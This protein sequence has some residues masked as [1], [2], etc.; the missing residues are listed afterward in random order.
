M[1]TLN[2]IG[3]EAVINHHNEVPYR[4]LR[5]NGEL[6][7]GDTGNGNLLV[8][9]D[10][11]EALKALLPYFAGQVKCIYIDPPYNTGH[12]DWV[13]SDSVSSPQMQTWLGKVVGGE[14]LSRHDK[15]LCMMYP[16]LR[17]LWELLSEGGSLW[18]S[19]DD[20]EIQS[21]RA[22]L[23]EIF[24]ERNFI[25]TICWQ[26]IYTVKSTA[27]H[28]SEMHDY[29]LVY[30]KDSATWTRNL[31]DRTEKQD[32]AYSNPDNDPRGPWK[33][34]PIHARNYYSEGQYAI[35]CPSGRVIPGPPT[36]TYWRYPESKFRALDEDNQIW[37]G[38][39]GNNVPAQKRFL[40][41]VK[42]GVVPATMWFYREAGHN[43]EAKNELRQILS[44]S[45][46]MFITP[47]P[48]R[49]VR[50]ILQ[51][52]TDSD[53]IV[54]DSFAGSGTTGHAVLQMNEEDRGNR[55]FIL[56]ELEQHIARTITAER[57]RRAIE[58]YEFTGTERTPLFEEKLTVTAFKKS[59][60]ILKQ[61]DAVREEHGDEY[62]GFERRIRD[63]KIV[64]YGKTKIEG[65]KEGL[66][67][68]FRYCTLGPSLFDETGAI[69]R[70]V[71]FDDLAA[72]VYFNETGEPLPQ[73][74]SSEPPLIG[75][76]GDTAYYLF[77]NG[78]RGDS[79]LDAHTLYQIEERAGSTVVYADGCTLSADTLKQHRITFKQIPYE[80][81]TR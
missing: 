7:V 31:L 78:V 39:D 50:R 9:G 33:A 30:A 52:A 6:S 76:A 13:Y 18:M 25:T 20:N 48:T 3:R 22:I 45:E 14:D 73:C 26:K 28:F 49:L 53:D 21:A 44:G 32:K 37:W 16:R 56:V 51:I 5:C 65:F 2:W 43:A 77:F 40:R 74:P 57:L 54:L 62:D 47:K 11:L 60:E 12:E 64:L 10:N 38:Q 70:E 79:Q 24:G 42:K 19:I 63:G 81:T 67:G 69:R 36:G 80:V 68:G 35:T 34:T 59:A 58:G 71:G 27:R 41:G 8:E 23:D 66:G 29:I 61:M 15:W 1:P 46:E 55:R 75:Q 17:L 72:H 4:L